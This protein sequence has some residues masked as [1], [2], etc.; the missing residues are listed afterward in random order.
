MGLIREPIGVDFI[1]DSRPLTEDEKL[2]ISEFIRTDKEKRRHRELQKRTI[3][4]KI[5]TPQPA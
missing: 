5:K 4:K 2:A 1:V 3:S